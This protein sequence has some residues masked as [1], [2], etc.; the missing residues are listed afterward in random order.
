MPD[1][2]H[3]TPMRK[4][5]TLLPGTAALAVLDPARG[6][7]TRSAADVQQGDE[8]LV[9]VAGRATFRAVEHALPADPP[10]AI[11]TIAADALAPGAPA[12]ALALPATLQV[13]SAFPPGEPAG[14]ETLAQPKAPS[15]QPAR[16][17]PA[18]QAQPSQTAWVALRIAAAD[19]IVVSGLAVLVPEI[20]AAPRALEGAAPLRALVGIREL[21]LDEALEQQDRITLRFT[22]PPRTSTLRL[23]SPAATPPGDKRRLG[24]AVTGL[25]L[26]DDELPLEGPALIRGFHRAEANDKLAWR[27]T[28]GEAL[29]VLTPRPGR[30]TFT[31]ALTTWHRALTA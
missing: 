8:V 27:W 14:A 28:D 29:L 19:R 6:V 20:A 10:E 30:V 15:R 2:A 23:S 21:D 26:G 16:R 11:V 9:Q 1:P 7:V 5:V 31:V 13:A 22:L 12:A 3:P 25:W 17:K 24:V 4:D 18:P